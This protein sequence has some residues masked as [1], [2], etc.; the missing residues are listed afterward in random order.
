MIR[1]G[2]GQ[3][4]VEGSVRFRD[5]KLWPGGARS[6]DWTE[7]G[8]DHEPGV[9][10]ADVAELLEHEPDVIVL[11][12]GRQRRL[13]VRPETLYL[14]GERGVEVVREETPTAIELY[15]RLAA[16]GRRVAALIH[17]TC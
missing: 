6:W 5:A 13:G 9:Q 7:T 15:N 1:H 3:I 4:E 2:W 14:L 10:P 11:S 12:Q 17:T 16:Q 8:T